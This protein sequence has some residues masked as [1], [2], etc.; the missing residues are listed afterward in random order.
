MK[1]VN[2]EQTRVPK[3]ES[4]LC[5]DCQT[6]YENN[7]AQIRRLQCIRCDR[8]MRGNFIQ[9]PSG[10][11]SYCRRKNKPVDIAPRCTKCTIYLFD[12]AEQAAF[13]DVLYWKHINHNTGSGKCPGCNGGDAQ[14]DKRPY[15]T[16]SP[17]Y[18]HMS[19][20]AS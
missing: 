16:S 3:S 6:K 5:P 10:Q 1:C 14:F 13:N 7:A 12:S 8:V 11:C 4:G 18:A 9:H 15:P 19:L 17:L 20:N 2:C